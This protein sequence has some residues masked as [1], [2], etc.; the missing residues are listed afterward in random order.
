MYPINLSG[1]SGIIFGV[2]NH[3]SIAWG[4]AEILHQAGMKLAIAYQNERVKERVSELVEKWDDAP[5]LIEC[6]VSNE[7][8]VNTT[9]K[10][11]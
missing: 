3:R 11:A 8:N 2:A 9:F 10:I 1:K 5:P 7:E 4:I 6:D